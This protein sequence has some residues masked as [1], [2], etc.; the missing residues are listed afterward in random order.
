[1][2]A[3]EPQDVRLPVRS[4]ALG[5]VGVPK[6][7]HE[8]PGRTSFAGQGRTHVLRLVDPHDPSTAPTLEHLD[9]FARGGALHPFP[10]DR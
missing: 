7:W 5:P 3:L 8:T 9:R 2:E 6:V 4:P 1:M 10:E